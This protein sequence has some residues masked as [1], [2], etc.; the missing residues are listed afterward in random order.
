M[1]QLKNLLAEGREIDN[2]KYYDHCRTYHL[3]T[4][5]FFCKRLSSQPE[6]IAWCSTDLNDYILSELSQS[7]VAVNNKFNPQ[8]WFGVIW[9]VW[10]DFP[11]NNKQFKPE[12]YDVFLRIN[13][14][15]HSYQVKSEYFD[16]LKEIFTE[17]ES[18]I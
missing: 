18:S 17:L 7:G 16:L 12:Y 3:K 15:P 2:Q 11:E 4:F 8:T 9:T 5:Y 14:K 6:N 10:R 13:G 1:E